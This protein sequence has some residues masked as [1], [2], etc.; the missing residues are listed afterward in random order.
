[1]PYINKELEGSVITS[2][3]Q[4]TDQEKMTLLGPNGSDQ[5]L[6]VIELLDGR[7]IAA[8]QDGRPATLLSLDEAGEEGMVF[9]DE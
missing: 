1:M 2:V 4:A 3:R 6:T 8:V 7:V 5:A 9:S